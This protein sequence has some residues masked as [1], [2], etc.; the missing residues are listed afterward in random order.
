MDISTFRLLYDWF[1]LIMFVY[2]F[3]SFRASF[4]SNFELFFFS[5]IA[6]LSISIFFSFFRACESM[7]TVA[8]D[9]FLLCLLLW[10]IILSMI[11]FSLVPHSNTK[12]N[13]ELIWHGKCIKYK[14]IQVN[15]MRNIYVWPPKRWRKENNEPKKEEKMQR[16]REKRHWI[17]K[18]FHIKRIEYK[19]NQFFLFLICSIGFFSLFSG[20]FSFLVAMWTENVSTVFRKLIYTST[21]LF[22]FFFHS[23]PERFFQSFRNAFIWVE[24]MFNVSITVATVWLVSYP[25]LT[26]YYVVYGSI[27]TLLRACIIYRSCTTL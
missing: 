26:R 9:K 3:Y 2:R 21:I 27:L 12:K 20:L 19:S 15:I 7:R 5:L 14:H 18:N 23:R 13:E 22:V 17:H 10:C 4:L 8:C 16:E 11:I 24:C 1:T 6:T 25:G